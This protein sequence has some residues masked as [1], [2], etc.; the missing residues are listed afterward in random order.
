MSTDSNN[1]M[2]LRTGEYALRPNEAPA[3]HAPATILLHWA[4]VL[5]VVIAVAAIYARELTEDKGLRILLLDLHRQLGLLII[6]GLV[7]RLVVRYVKGFADH[8]GEMHALLRWAALLTHVALYA[9]LLAI[10][11]LGW[12]ASNAHDIKLNLFGLIPLPNLVKADSDFADT[13]DDYHKWAAWAAGV[14]VLM[15]AAAA[16]WHHYV[17]KDAVL[18]AMLPGRGSR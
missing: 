7:L 12:A 15:H 13:L 1:A 6:I 16:L 10:P 11:L 9:A 2:P 18:T 3:K 8:A 17:R 4:T 14:L 5:A